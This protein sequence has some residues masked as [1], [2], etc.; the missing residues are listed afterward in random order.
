MN[1]RMLWLMQWRDWQEVT[2]VDAV[3]TLEDA[4]SSSSSLTDLDL[5]SSVWKADDLVVPLVCHVV[6]L[7]TQ[8]TPC[9]DL[10]NGHFRFIRR[11]LNYTFSHRPF[12]GVAQVCCLEAKLLPRN[13]H[14]WLWVRQLI[15]GRLSRKNNEVTN[16]SPKNTGVVISLN[17]SYVLCYTITQL[18]RN[19]LLS[20]NL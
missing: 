9:T 10:T 1:R 17:V 8:I 16:R 5:Q 3:V 2:V 11:P 13:A 20:L 7:Q 4:L 6:R 14:H 18:F 15:R 12:R 19:K